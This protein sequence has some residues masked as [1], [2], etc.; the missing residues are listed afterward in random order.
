MFTSKT[1]M[2]NAWDKITALSSAP[3]C[4]WVQC[5]IQWFC[6]VFFL[7]HRSYGIIGQCWPLLSYQWC[8]CQ[9]FGMLCFRQKSSLFV[10]VNIQFSAGVG[11][12]TTHNDAMMHI[13]KMMATDKCA[14]INFVIH[15]ISLSLSLSLSC[16]FYVQHQFSPWVI[17]IFGLEH[18]PHL[19]IACWTTTR[20]V[21]IKFLTIL[22]DSSNVHEIFLFNYSSEHFFVIQFYWYLIINCMDFI[23]T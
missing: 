9:C 12:H 20:P 2:F 23:Y 17:Q 16:F 14:S 1:L 13:K 15:S 22:Y 4:E 5:C 19:N 7:A 8:G 21:V 10:I 6:V 3:W 11:M 18:V